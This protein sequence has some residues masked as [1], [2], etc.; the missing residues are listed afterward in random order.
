MSPGEMLPA[1]MLSLQLKSVQYGPRNLPFKF[2]QNWASN[3]GD[4]ADIEFAVVGGGGGVPC[5]FCVK[6]KL[7]LRIG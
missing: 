3:S 7:R 2:G 4:I 5:H 6:P 1:Q